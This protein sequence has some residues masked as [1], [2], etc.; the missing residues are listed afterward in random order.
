[1]ATLS[2][3]HC[4]RVR[5]DMRSKTAQRVL[6]KLYAVC[7]KGKSTSAK[8]YTVLLSREFDFPNPSIENPYNS[9]SDAS[10][11][12]LDFERSLFLHPIKLTPSAMRG[13]KSG[14]AS[15]LPFASIHS[16]RNRSRLKVE[17]VLP[18]QRAEPP[19]MP[20][21]RF[22]EENTV[23]SKGIPPLC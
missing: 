7:W 6:S 11:N 13:H 1:M 14:E 4:E 19:V 10:E 5:A 15:G 17:E 3:D 23:V 8:K 18:L 2:N 12:K 22:G 20:I 21:S 16:H 9:S